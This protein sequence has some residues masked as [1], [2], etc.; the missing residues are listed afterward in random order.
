[1]AAQKLSDLLPI[2]ESASSP[3][4]YQ[5]FGLT[6]GEQDPGKINA[7]VQATVARLRGIKAATD[8]TLWKRAAG[9][10]QA[11]RVTLADPAKKAELDARFGIIPVDPQ[12]SPTQPSP[13]QPASVQPVPAQPDSRQP[14]S[15]PS[16]KSDPL[17]GM[18]PPV[19][20]MA[21]VMPA[22]SPSPSAPHPFPIPG[23]AQT[24]NPLGGVPSSAPVHPSGFGDVGGPSPSQMPVSPVVATQG[25]PRPVIRRAKVVKTR[26][27]SLIGNLVMAT[28]LLGMIT[29][30]GSLAYFLFW[31]PGT[32]AISSQGGALTISTQP[33]GAASSSGVSTP[34]PIDDG[35]RRSA[36]LPRRFD[37]VMGGMR[38]D[39]PTT[40]NATSVPPPDLM[41]D[42]PIMVGGNAAMT[43]ATPPPP[44]MMGT[45]TADDAMATVETGLGEPVNGEPSMQMP[46]DNTAMSPPPIETSDADVATA[47]AAIEKVGEVIRSHQWDQMKSVAEA[48][49]SLPMN[50]DQ[51]LLAEGLYQ[52]ADLASYYQGGIQ[53]GVADLQVGNDFEVRDDFRVV[54]VEKG[55]DFL[56]VRY[57]AKN[58]TFKF[59]EFPFPLAAKLAA[60]SI[61]E[62]PT[63]QAAMVIY[64]TIAPISNEGYRDEAIEV[65]GRLDGQVED[66]D[67]KLMQDAIRYLYPGA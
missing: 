38:D 11:A 67:T 40:S 60:F 12:P 56:V 33:Q 15:S 8:P 66:A 52:L 45:P 51:K 23:G 21:P 17:A 13:T 49:L 42:Q 22:A 39:V 5:V 63:R 55:D 30:I 35:Q 18:L 44:A 61:A 26:R 2:Q 29:L 10:V 1:M 47:D 19:N 65:L 41:L 36:K 27:S 46:M 34:R 7:A 50:A 28:V 4:A 43:P 32:L 16:P 6:A 3:H 31:G 9:L 24:P 37:P 59:D 54:I 20:P 62:G 53:R 57:N 25:S 64:Q 14:K 58:R 48:T